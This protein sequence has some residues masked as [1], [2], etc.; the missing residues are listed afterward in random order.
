MLAILSI[1]I[2]LVFV[3]LLFSMLSSALL[4]LIDAVVSLRGRH[5]RNTLQNMLGDEAESFF[6]H[7][8]FK[9]LCYAAHNRSRVTENML[10]SWV[11]KETFSAIVL[12]ILN[13]HNKKDLA[14]QIDKMDPGD[15]RRIL[16]FLARQS[17][18]QLTDFKD[19][20]EY[21]FDEIMQR[22]TDW[23]RKHTRR[24]LF[25]IGVVLAA[26]FNAD[27]IQIYKG[28]SANAAARDRLGELAAAFAA[29]RDSIPVSPKGTSVAQAQAEFAQLSSM[30]QQIVQSPLGLGWQTSTQS[31][32]NG[33]WWW[34]VKI[35]GLGLTGLAVTL[36][37]Q[38]WFDVLKNLLALRPKLQTVPS[39]AP[40][41]A[42]TQPPVASKAPENTIQSLPVTIL[43]PPTEPS[44]PIVGDPVERVVLEEDP[45]G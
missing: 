21:W 42:D 13:A 10:P 20:I 44:T 25:V 29:G 3:L 9:Q 14:T 11:N 7:P 27:T 36:G 12:D 37:A 28:L 6:K 24:Y 38:F 31:S 16:Q 30:Y 23:Y 15:M 8:I 1:L 22:A 45:V 34:L 5:L 26:I 18:E 4:E 33:L 2:G 41:A 40:K 35:A 17:D 39:S 19:R 43:P 32:E